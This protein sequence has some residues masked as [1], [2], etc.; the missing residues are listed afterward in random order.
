MTNLFDELSEVRYEINHEPLI[1]TRMDEPSVEPSDIEIAES[2]FSVDLFAA[3]ELALLI[4]SEG[5]EPLERWKVNI[6]DSMLRDAALIVGGRSTSSMFALEEPLPV[7]LAFTSQLGE[8]IE[9][10][11]ALAQEM[12]A[13]SAL[14]T[15]VSIA[16]PE[17]TY[18]PFEAT[19]NVSQIVGSG[20]QSGLLVE[21]AKRSQK[22]I[23]NLGRP[24]RRR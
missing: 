13:A 9:S 11:D 16:K 19:C 22:R 10:L 1:E 3:F 12:G 21:I 14:D 8:R 17:I 20:M 18:G 2:G 23:R 15:I 24:R 4:A 5:G 7:M 6:V